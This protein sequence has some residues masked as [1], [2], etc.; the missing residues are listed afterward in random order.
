M[1]RMLRAGVPSSLARAAHEWVRT[2]VN[3]PVAE[4][5]AGGVEWRCGLLNQALRE[6][7]RRDPLACAQLEAYLYQVA[8]PPYVEPPSPNGVDAE[9]GPELTDTMVEGAEVSL[10]EM[11]RLRDDVESL[12]VTLG[13]SRLHGA[14]V[15]GFKAT[16][17]GD[18]EQVY[19]W[20][21]LALDWARAVD[22]VAEVLVP[23]WEASHSVP[24]PTFDPWLRIA[25]KLGRP[26][27]W[28][29]RLWWLQ[30]LRRHRRHV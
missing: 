29:G 27:P 9:R 17:H 2:V 25:F 22:L 19:T 16:Q 12:L 20:E 24:E 23:T 5:L 1:G 3:A 14:N 26:V 6:Y 21:R 4:C 10:W 8:D 11:V 13:V 7:M 30:L 15:L 18:D 28:G